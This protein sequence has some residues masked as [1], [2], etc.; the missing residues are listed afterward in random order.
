MTGS[1]RLQAE[2]RAPACHIGDRNE[3]EDLLSPADSLIAA[4]PLPTQ[5][6]EADDRSF[7]TFI[8]PDHAPNVSGPRF[9]W[10]RAESPPGSIL[11]KPAD[12]VIPQ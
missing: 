7:P 10:P 3:A 2:R 9:H 5:K 12:P 4:F 1:N 11:L 6:G 8:D